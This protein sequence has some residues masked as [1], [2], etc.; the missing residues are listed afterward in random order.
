MLVAF[1]SFSNINIFLKQQYSKNFI[2]KKKAFIES[3]Y[4]SHKQV[5]LVSN[6]SS[7]L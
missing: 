1:Y 4:G 2:Q 5:G 7:D 6:C 3:S